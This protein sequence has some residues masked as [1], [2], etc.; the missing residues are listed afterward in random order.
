M[1]AIVTVNPLAQVL[2]IRVG[3]GAEFSKKELALLSP[4]M[5]ESS[6]IFR[7]ALHDLNSLNLRRAGPG[8]T[9]TVGTVNPVSANTRWN[10]LSFLG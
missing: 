10:P 5:R 2:R 7:S 6:H 9:P 8:G 3:G 4:R 1:A